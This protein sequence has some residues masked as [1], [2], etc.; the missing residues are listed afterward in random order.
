MIFPT[1]FN[2]QLIEEMKG[3]MQIVW[4]LWE[5]VYPRCGDNIFEIQTN[6]CYGTNILRLYI[7]K[8][9]Q[10]VSKALTV[11]SGEARGYVTNVL[12]HTAKLY[13]AQESLM[14]YV[15]NTSVVSDRTNIN[16]Y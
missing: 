15:H 11:Y 10:N 7:D 5:G 1:L 3:L 12:T 14:F 9:N 16:A 8:N 6:V 4:E 13:L 2:S